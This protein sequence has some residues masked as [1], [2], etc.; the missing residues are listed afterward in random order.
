MTI[1]CCNC[2]IHISPNNTN[3]CERCIISKNNI[4]SNIKTNTV[5]ESC[6]GCERY[7]VPPKSFKEYAWGSQDLLL[8]CLS[9]NKTVKKLNIVDANFVYTEEHSMRMQIEVKIET[10]GVIQPVTLN[11]LIRNKQCGDCMRTESKQFWNSV[12]Q[13]RQHPSNTRTFLYLEQL[14]KLH[15]AHLNT[16][17]IKSRKEGIDFF[18]TNKTNALK[19]T[20]FLENFY[21]VKVRESNRLISEDR[22]NNTTNMKSTFSCILL[23]FCKDDLVSI[24]KKLFLVS[25]VNS[26]VEFID[27]ETGTVKIVTNKQFFG[28]EQNY[29]KLLS[30]K[31]ANEYDVLIITENKEGFYDVTIVDDCDRVF[32]VKT[33]FKF[34]EG[35]RVLGYYAE[36]KA[37]LDEFVT[38]DVILFRKYNNHS[39]EYVLKVN[40]EMDREL[41]LFIEDADKDMKHEIIEEEME[42]L[43]KKFISVMK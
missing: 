26:S 4:S 2:G 38:D 22:S 13:V 34:K 28:N 23:P 39:K 27:L 43:S 10:D 3:M 12:V 37:V 15:G 9:R 29:I 17:N 33:K 25:K 16:S 1:L 32:E 18:F 5:I 31:E 19:F 20:K 35:D 14:I 30:S 11:Y 7:F 24:S 41:R 40:K 21:G 6:R 8:F 42:D 36:G